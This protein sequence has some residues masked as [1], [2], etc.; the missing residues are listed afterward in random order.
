MS[1]S[2]AR[3]HPRASGGP[4]CG[5]R[6]A[7]RRRSGVL[8]SQQPGASASV[9]VCRRAGNHF[10]RLLLLLL[11]LLLSTSTERKAALLRQHAHTAGAR[12]QRAKDPLCAR[13]ITG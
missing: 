5:W 12:R 7:R 6:E 1:G 11:L 3:R 2:R 10:V 4:G 13:W 8:P 9:T